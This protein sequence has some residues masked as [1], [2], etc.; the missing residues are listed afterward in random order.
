MEQHWKT[1]KTTLL[2]TS[3]DT[4]G[5]KT[6]RHQ[7]WFDENYIE[8]QHLIDAK[9]K[10]FCTWQNDINCRAKRQAH[11]KAKALVQS[12]VRELKNQ[13][14]REKALEIQRLADSGDTRG[15]FNATKAVYGPSYRGLNPLRSKDGQ[16]LLKESV[17]ISSRW[18]EHFHELLNRNTT[19]K[20]ETIE[21]IPQRPIMEHLVDPPTENEVRD[22]LRKLSNNKASGPDGI[23]AEILKQGGPKLLSHIHSLLGKIWDQDQ[24]YLLNSGTP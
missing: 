4:I 6:K 24:I 17:E 2:E 21:Q 14:W 3:R 12:R 19:L 16:T 13:W 9:R 1:L 15:F 20:P 7:D 18:R 5:Y 10:A 11:S 8:I 23:P 22:A